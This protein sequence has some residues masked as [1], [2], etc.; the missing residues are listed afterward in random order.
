M[1]DKEEEKGLD[2]ILFTTPKNYVDKQLE[3]M[4]ETVNKIQK[5]FAPLDALK[6]EDYDKLDI[7]HLS[8]IKEAGHSICLAIKFNSDDE[9]RLVYGEKIEVAI[10][11]MI[12]RSNEG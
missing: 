1:E 5:V 8:V 12:R 10:E 6:Q 4:E 11:E 3:E 9:V 7:E 2:P